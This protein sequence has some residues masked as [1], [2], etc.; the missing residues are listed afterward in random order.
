MQDG[1]EDVYERER[2]YLDYYDDD[3]DDDEKNYAYGRDP[4][5][6]DAASYQKQLLRGS[7]SDTGAKRRVARGLLSQTIHEEDDSSGG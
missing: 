6:L 1:D 4:Y 7:D 5:G 3:E 2:D